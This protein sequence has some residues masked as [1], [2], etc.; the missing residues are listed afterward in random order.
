[1]EAGSALG[2]GPGVACPPTGRA[3]APAAPARGRRRLDQR[4][5]RDDGDD[6][7]R[8]DRRRA[9]CRRA[10]R[11]RCTRHVHRRRSVRGVRHA[12]AVLPTGDRCGDLLKG[13]T[14]A[15]SAKG[16]RRA[17]DVRRPPPRRHRRLAGAR[18]V[19]APCCV[20]PNGG[21]SGVRL[22]AGT[23]GGALA[24]GTRDGRT[25]WAAALQP[26]SRTACSP[27]QRRC[28]TSTSPTPT[29]G[30]SAASTYGAGWPR[31][32]ACRPSGHWPCWPVM[33]TAPTTPH[34]QGRRAPIGVRAPQS[35][36]VDAA[37]TNGVRRATNL[38][39]GHHSWERRLCRRRGGRRWAGARYV[40]RRM[41]RAPTSC[42]RPVVAGFRRPGRRSGHGRPA[43]HGCR[44]AVG[45]ETPIRDYP[46]N[47]STRRLCSSKSSRTP[48]HERDRARL[49]RSEEQVT[50]VRDWLIAN[51]APIKTPQIDS[52]GMKHV[53]EDA[54]GDYVSNGELIA[55]ALMAGYPMGHPH[56]P[57]VAFGMSKRDVDEA[58]G[59]R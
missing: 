27:P 13:V 43:G 21:D 51:V 8:D 24:A 37:R 46:V 53:V 50:R 52:Y 56:G 14:R 2:R 44:R 5:T 36:T 47:G 30:A 55:A 25:R 48:G 35:A 42:A 32:H 1:M 4:G 23:R 15:P 41:V 26:R 39:S 29:V 31:T 34:R 19:R 45:G 12:G 6:A 57:N 38:P 11:A 28:R 33:M 54:V 59:S 16:D 58:R 49:G 7:L 17:A 9:A 3:G 10:T 22:V 18:S 40:R 20:V